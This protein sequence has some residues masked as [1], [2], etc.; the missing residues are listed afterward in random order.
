MHHRVDADPPEAFQI[1]VEH[2]GRRRLHDHLQLVVMLQPVGVLAVAPV[3]GPARGL[4]IDR[5]PG[6]GAERAQS[7]GG[8]ERAGA[9][10]HIVGLQ[11]HA[12][13]LAPELLE[14]EDQVLKGLGG[15]QRR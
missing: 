7:G 11:H 12:A 13:L 2:I 14:S 3:L 1:E 9:H 4:H 6:L 5:V 8:M 15:P 10:F